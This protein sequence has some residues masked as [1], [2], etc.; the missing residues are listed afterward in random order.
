MGHP[1]E[2]DTLTETLTST[3]STVSELLSEKTS[4]PVMSPAQIL[5]VVNRDGLPVAEVVR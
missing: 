5:V 2:S 1:C 4:Y 3:W